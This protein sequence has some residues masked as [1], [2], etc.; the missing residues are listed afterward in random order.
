MPPCRQR[1]P[2]LPPPVTG[3]CANHH[4]RIIQSLAYTIG[5]PASLIAQFD[6]FRKKRNIGGYERAG[7]TSD[8][9]AKEMFLL[10]TK[11]RKDVEAWL[12][13]THHELMG[14]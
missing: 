14:K 12:R 1:Q 5:I 9:E 7:T 8:Q 2:P 4:Y 3:R 11:L 6:Q 10:A 13:E